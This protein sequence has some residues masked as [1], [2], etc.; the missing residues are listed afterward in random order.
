MQV[1]EALIQFIKILLRGPAKEQVQV[2]A[3]RYYPVLQVRR[4]DGYV[5]VDS[6]STVR[7]VGLSDNDECQVRGE[8][9]EYFNQTMFSR[10]ARQRDS[11][12]A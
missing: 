8:L 1:G 6:N 3:H 7:A 9:H 4:G 10:A 5:D 11:D 12:D 2:F